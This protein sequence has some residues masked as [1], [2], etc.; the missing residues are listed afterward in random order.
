MIYIND[1]DKERILAKDYTGEASIVILTNQ[2]NELLLHLRDDIPEIIYPNYWTVPGGMREN[3]ET[4][5][6]AA[7]R[8]VL[9]ETG[10]RAGKLRLFAHTIDTDGRNELISVYEGKIDK[11]ISELVLN[12]GADMQYFAFSKIAHLKIIPFVKKVL[13]KYAETRGLNLG[14]SNTPGGSMFPKP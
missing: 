6:E 13:Q 1:N 3:N 8:E 10:F 12:E 4:A 7:T 11:D 5:E 2:N 14:P 9:E